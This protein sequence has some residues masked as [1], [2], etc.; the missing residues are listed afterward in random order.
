MLNFEDDIPAAPR[1]QPAMPPRA[2]NPQPFDP[3]YL[4]FGVPAQPAAAPTTP[5]FAKGG[6]GGISPAVPNPSTASGTTAADA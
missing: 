2:Q 3:A 5:P 1:L 4:S 6:L